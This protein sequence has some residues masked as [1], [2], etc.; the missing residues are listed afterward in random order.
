MALTPAGAGAQ[1][2]SGLYEAQLRRAVA[3]GSPVV[4]YSALPPGMGLREVVRLRGSPAHTTRFYVITARR[5][6]ETP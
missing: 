2:L 6:P 5:R 3:T 4:D 1:G